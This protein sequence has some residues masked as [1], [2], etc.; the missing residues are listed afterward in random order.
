LESQLLSIFDLL[1]AGL[2]LLRWLIC[3]S[4][5]AVSRRRSERP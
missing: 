3:P 5:T 1:I 4:E 2:P